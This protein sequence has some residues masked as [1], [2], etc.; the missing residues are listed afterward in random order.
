MKN[1]LLLSLL[2]FFPYFLFSQVDFRNNYDASTIPPDLLLNA[3][4]VV[5]LYNIDFKI[6]NNSN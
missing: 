5:R 3:N 1:Y 6:K 2:F 4:A